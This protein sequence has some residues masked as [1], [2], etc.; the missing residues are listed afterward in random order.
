M[1]DK[2]V[3]NIEKRRIGRNIKKESEK[4]EERK[5]EE[6]RGSQKI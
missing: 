3:I 6:R 5:S 1:K 2:N 4:E